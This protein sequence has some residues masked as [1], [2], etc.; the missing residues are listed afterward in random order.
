M[1][2]QED[3]TRDQDEEELDVSGRGEESSGFILNHEL[4]TDKLRKGI[5]TSQGCSTQ[6]G[7]LMKFFFFFFL[8]F[9]FRTRDQ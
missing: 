5:V 9:L 6:T 4:S 8:L 3:G 1:H 7:L 2:Q